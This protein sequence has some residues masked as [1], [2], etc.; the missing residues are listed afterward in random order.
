[1]EVKM[2]QLL[3]VVSQGFLLEAFLQGKELLSV[4]PKSVPKQL[5]N[6]YL[7]KPLSSIPLVAL[8][9]PGHPH[10]F[11]LWFVFSI[12][13]RSGRTAEKF[14]AALLLPCIILNAN[15]RTRMVGRP[16]N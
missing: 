8:A 2:K 4:L 7:R 16:G 15:Q 13:H 3:Q 12:I 10:F 1:M 6:R 11:V 14:F 9:F 5:L